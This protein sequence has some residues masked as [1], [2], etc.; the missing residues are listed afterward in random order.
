MVELG[1]ETALT[2]TT[3][4]SFDQRIDQSNMLFVI[5]FL[6]EALETITLSESRPS[7][8]VHNMPLSAFGGQLWLDGQTV[9]PGIIT[10]RQLENDLYVL[11]PAMAHTHFFIMNTSDYFVIDAQKNASV[12]IQG[13]AQI[14]IHEDKVRLE[15]Q[16]DFLYFNDALVQGHKMIDHVQTGDR[17]LTREF[18]LE[19]R[20]TQ[21]K[22]T[23]FTTEV[24]LQYGQLLTQREER[25]FPENFPQYRRS[26]RIHLEPP[27]EKFQIE[28][29][30]DS[31]QANKNSLLQAILP[32]IG[33][34]AVSGMTTM[35][36]G[37][38]PLM[39]IGMG[40][41]SCMT[42]SF[43]ISQ[44]VNE[45]KE[46]K[47]DEQTRQQNYNTYLVNI[48]AE[49]GAQYKAETEI[50]NFKQPAPAQLRTMIETYDARIY[51]RMANNKD[52]LEIAVGTGQVA[53]QLSVN[54]EIN[55]RDTDTNTRRVQRLLE[56][57]R[58]QRHAPITINLRQQTVG[59]VGMAPVLRTAMS[60][61]LLQIAFFHSYRDVNFISLIPEDDYRNGWASWRFLPH[62]KLAE[63]GLRGIVHNAKTRDI[64]LSSFYQLLNKRKQVLAEAGKEV[65]QFSPHYIFTIFDDGYLAGHGLNEFLAEDMSALGVSVIWT[66]EDKKLLPETVTALVSYKNQRVGEIVNDNNVYVAKEFEP[67]GEVEAVEKS[68]RQLANLEHVEV[69]KNAVPE[70]LT[71]LE[72]YEVKDV[73]QLKI[74]DRWA[75]AEPNKSIKSLI[76]WR[77]KGEYM[78]W[79]LHERVHGPHALVGGTTGSGKSE[80]LT[81]YLIGLAINFS[82]EDIGMLIIDWKGGGIA[83]TLAGLPHFMGS[84]TN[85][86]GAGTARALASIK[87][88]LD[89]RMKEFAKYGVNSINS[90][91]SLYKRRHEAKPDVN[92]PDEPIPHLVLVSDEFA[93]LK[94]N[95]PEFLDELT[96]VA[97]IGRSLGVHLILATQKPSGVVNDQIEANST[98]KIA[99]KM[100]SK[101]DSNELL[102]THDAAHITNPGRGYLKVGENEVYDLFQSG[103]AGVPYD[104]GAEVRDIVDERIHKITEL[105][106][107]EVAYDPGEA[108][109][110]G[111]DASDLPTQLEAVITEITQVFDDSNMRLPA[112]PWL[113]SLGTE[114]FSP[115]VEQ[116]TK[117]NMRIPL[118]LMDVPA[119]QLQT[120]YEFD[121]NEANHTA[122]FSSPGFGKSTALQTIVMN[123]ARQNTPEHVHFNLFDFG[124]NG[125]LPLKDLPHVADIVSLEEN[126]KLTKMIA[127]LQLVLAERKQAFKRAGVASISQYE[128]KM[129]QTLPI[130]I[131]LL[132]NYDALAQSK[133]R[134]EID[135]VLIQILREGAA[136]GVY[137]ILT[138]GRS[139]VVRMNMMSNIQTKIGLF[140]ND[141]HELSNLFGR[142]RLE[143]SEIIGRAQMKLEFVFA[144]QIYLPIRGDN[145]LERIEA[146]EA[147]IKQLDESWQGARPSAI[148][149]VPDELTI[150]M[151]E[152]YVPVRNSK[153]LYLGLDKAS[154]QPVGFD[155]FT[156][157]SL[158]IFPANRQQLQFVAPFLFS[159]LTTHAESRELIIIDGLKSLES[160]MK[161]ATIYISR[162]QLA[163]QTA[164]VKEAFNH[165]IAE[166]PTKQRVI[167]I[168]GLADFLTK[169]TYQQ[170]QFTTLI[171]QNNMS[172][173]FIFMDYVSQ[174]GNNY[175]MAT[176]AIRDNVNQILFGGDLNTQHF[177]ENL[178]P[179]IKRAS[180][181][182]HVLHCVKDE[183]LSHIVIPTQ[184]TK[185]E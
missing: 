179:E 51:E 66:K 166:K 23:T 4:G 52:F 47:R 113:P 53:S 155:L 144:L 184:R 165:L 119:E 45:K 60:N 17:I 28:K 164:D 121:L 68:V 177:I 29:A 125:L 116:A 118:G 101:Q 73:A 110:Q 158:G 1:F 150:E 79:D 135:E 151:F 167:I 86:D 170:P 83:N 48:S 92:Y 162:E 153:T 62:F 138:A 127:Q 88:E 40:F 21:W 174:V 181:E 65:P 99:L 61:L 70:S 136:V 172:T 122:I 132:D 157:K 137:L 163:M 171:E 154:S 95:V 69:A 14:V 44:Y 96:S 32:P 77:G 78:Y 152:S 114:L 42:A 64:V 130:I 18:L 12:M 41:M 8:S 169:L 129:Q 98:S 6:G 58:S 156:G 115:L 63:L 185:E 56:H 59:L 37:G 10:L 80:F 84:I 103:Y 74:A 105:G 31:L 143:Q 139:N 49:I 168:N 25:E 94:A 123:I 30:Q 75:A 7:T 38:N 140:M 182:R 176:I 108:V 111:A 128:Q 15:A 36:S 149:M 5:Y 183:D 109:I 43:T 9:E 67:Y 50:L 90:Y 3:T 82:P 46:H 35:L 131:N 120:P 85:L 93:E 142:D 2:K 146:M 106:Q 81:T 71:L 55:N 160:Y 11:T 34:V 117:R 133:R 57:Y 20:R 54:S 126:E 180:F 22:L 159:E 97:R 100:A 145:D 134:E 107:F 104:F 19:K 178:P 27:S 16:N 175:G 91:M 147:E 24:V 76:G 173:Q 141:E 39:M 13:D 102:K 33:M 72:Q 89:K 87:A 124:T 26:P 161:A 112:K 148:P